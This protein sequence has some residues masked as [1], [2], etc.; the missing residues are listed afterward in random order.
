[1]QL[2]TARKLLFA[3]CSAA[4]IMTTEIGSA[5]PRRRGHDNK[6]WPTPSEQPAGNQMPAHT[7][8]QDSGQLP[9]L[10]GAVHQL[11]ASSSQRVDNQ[12]WRQ[13]LEIHPGL[14]GAV[15]QSPQQ[16]LVFVEGQGL[17]WLSYSTRNQSL[18]PYNALQ[19]VIQSPDGRLLPG[20]IVVDG[21]L[22]LLSG[23]G[24]VPMNQN[25]SAST[26][27]LAIEQLPQNE[28][29]QVVRM[30]HF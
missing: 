2:H 20:C 12:M 15:D 27:N 24:L 4:T 17:T 21:K 25:E 9:C 7:Q 13:D 29:M 10:L 5:G 11:P 18:L 28:P 30:Y 3:M 1:M 26:T 22:H 19:E 16:A 8:G 23:Y 14:L 6:C